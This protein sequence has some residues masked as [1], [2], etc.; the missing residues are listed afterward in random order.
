[1]AIDTSEYNWDITYNSDNLK[2]LDNLR[3]LTRRETTFFRLLN[4]ADKSG[5]DLLLEY[6][7]ISIER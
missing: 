2:Y 5:E 7:A 4:F 1:M 6:D 3:S